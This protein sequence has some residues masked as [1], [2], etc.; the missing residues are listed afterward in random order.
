MSKRPRYWPLPAQDQFVTLFMRL[1]EIYNCRYPNVLRPIYKKKLRQILK[2]RRRCLKK[3]L[4]N[5][6]MERGFEKDLEVI[7]ILLGFIFFWRL[8]SLP[9]W[10]KLESGQRSDWPHHLLISPRSSNYTAPPPPLLPP[11]SPPPSTCPPP[12]PHLTLLLLEQLMVQG[13]F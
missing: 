5:S 7:C 2:Q 12:H 9:P 11:P 1:P 4:A 13:D 6:I 10:D 8:P 3:Q